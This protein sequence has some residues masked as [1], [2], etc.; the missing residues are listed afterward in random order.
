MTEAA[1]LHS[2]LCWQARI[3]MDLMSVVV[4]K[5]KS[6]RTTCI[7]TAARGRGKSAALGIFV[8]VCFGGGPLFGCSPLCKGGVALPR[9]W[10]AVPFDVSPLYGYVHTPR[11]ICSLHGLC[12]CV[13]VC[14]RAWVRACARALVCVPRRLIPDG[15][16]LISCCIIMSCRNHESHVREG[17]VKAVVHG[18]TADTVKCKALQAQLLPCTPSHTPHPSHAWRH[19]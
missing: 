11:Q 8:G 12:A 14:V 5:E 15:L 17:L 1:D 13:C 2:L 18:S 3:I 16:D 19:V 9:Q 4:E 7:V 10:N 6:M